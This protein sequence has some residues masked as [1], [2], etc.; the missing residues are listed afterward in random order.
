MTAYII[1]FSIASAI[2]LILGSYL[3]Y[4]YFSVARPEKESYRRIGENLHAGTWKGQWY[5]GRDSIV[6]MLSIVF[7]ILTISFVMLILSF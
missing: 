1:G 3:M 4:Y 6:L 5:R 7:F 2:F